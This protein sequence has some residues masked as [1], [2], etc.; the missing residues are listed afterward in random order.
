MTEKSHH[1]NPLIMSLVFLL[2]SAVAQEYARDR[3]LVKLPPALGRIGFSTSIDREPLRVDQVVIPRL[4]IYTVKIDTNET[5]VEQA[6]E[7]VRANPW[8]EAAQL[9]HWVSLRSTI[10]ND[11]SFTK[12]W[13]LNNT[14]QQVFWLNDAD[15]DAP[16]AWDITTGGINAKGDTIVV[17]VIDDGFDIDH[18][19]LAANLWVNYTELYGIADVD[20]DGNGYIDDIHGWNA[21]S[22]SGLMVGDDHGTHVA[23]IIGAV[24][25]NIRQVAGINWN[26]KILPVIGASAF[27]STVMK[28]YNYVLD[29][30]LAYD[31]SG[32]AAGA[33]VIAT[34]SS[35]GINYAD[36]NSG[37]YPLW[38]AMY[39][40]LGNLGIINI[41]ATMNVAADVDTAGDVPSSCDSDYLVTVTNT[42]YSDN[43]NT[44]AAYGSVTID[45]GA[46]GTYIYSLYDQGGVGNKTGTSMATPQVTG[47]VGLM[48]SIFT[49][50][51]LDY[52]ANYPAAAVLVIKEMLLSSVD[53]LS[54]LTNE[55]VSN[56][57]LNLY[58]AVLKAQAYMQ[59]D[60]LDPAPVSGL[61][62]DTSQWFHVG[63]TWV[64]PD[65]LVNGDLITDCSIYVYRDDS[66]LASIGSGVGFFTDSGLQGGEEILYSLVTH[67]TS[68]DSTSMP[69]YLTVTVSGPAG[70]LGDVTDDGV[71]NSTD[72][73]RITAI[74]LG[75]ID[76]TTQDFTRAD[77]D[78]NGT[79]DVLDL[80]RIAGSF[81]NS[82]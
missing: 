65:T 53:T 54:T 9:D 29:Q 71:V 76:A 42:T 58:Q 17:A 21:K 24:A 27:T 64:D 10:P 56:G 79:I 67:L 61:V 62:A 82:E 1:F 39:N 50:E 80:I 55:T 32:G 22:S 26:I 69:A 2:T 25:D 48:H 33:F 57:R 49:P 19:D 4:G 47:A 51:F 73:E 72:L 77:V 15:I 75:E 78:F 30:R 16:E 8:V 81:L 45:L 34:N 5:S 44:G 31:Q 23:G 43:L 66:L 12:Q 59:P 60:T 74:I 41:A 52:Y 36:C 13:A 6:L 70:I 20:D 37:D 18:P 46:P 63:L 68:S 7:D 28:A 38:N 40:T 35:F 14:G 3:I 11:T